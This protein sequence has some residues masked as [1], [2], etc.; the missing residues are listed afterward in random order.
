MGIKETLWTHQNH[1]MRRRLIAG[2]ADRCGAAQGNPYGA[3]DARPLRRVLGIV[4]KRPATDGS[5]T[6]G[7]ICRRQPRLKPT[8]YLQELPSGGLLVRATSR[9]K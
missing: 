5:E 4:F 1:G 8:R 6:M 7:M 2:L 3:R 9:L